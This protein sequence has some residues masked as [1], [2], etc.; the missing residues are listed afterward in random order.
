MARPDIGGP[1]EVE[2]K[3]CPGS[4]DRKESAANMLEEKRENVLHDSSEKNSSTK[5]L[6]QITGCLSISIASLGKL[7]LG[8]NCKGFFLKTK[9][10]CS[11]NSYRANKIS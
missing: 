4:G 11:L 3:K 1:S 9:T 8:E 5:L 7:L 10:Q 2:E 6:G